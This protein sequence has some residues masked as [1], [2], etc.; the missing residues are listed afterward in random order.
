MHGDFPG[1]CS[2]SKSFCSAVFPEDEGITGC[3]SKWGRKE[4]VEWCWVQR[5][6]PR[7]R[8]EHVTWDSWTGT[9]LSVTPLSCLPAHHIALHSLVGA[10]Q[11]SP[12][13]GKVVK[14]CLTGGKVRPAAPTCCLL[15][16]LPGLLTI[17]LVTAGGQCTR[18]FPRS[19]LSDPGTHHPPSTPHP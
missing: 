19:C 18:C 12:W 8:G 7:G 10:T 13:S 5:H 11:G 6:T 3:P 16:A 1:R 4:R 9:L 17:Q 2:Q 15:P 14:F